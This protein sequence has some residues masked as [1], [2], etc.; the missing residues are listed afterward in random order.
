MFALQWSC[1]EEHQW[2]EWIYRDYVKRLINPRITYKNQDSLITFIWRD[3]N[4]PFL[5]TGSAFTDLTNL[6]LKIF[7]EKIPES[8]KKQNLNLLHAG[9]YLNSIYI[10][11]ITIYI[12]F[13]L[14]LQSIS[15]IISDVEMIWSIWEECT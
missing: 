13:T 15:D 9:N 8:S 11:R 4:Q 6:R 1:H 5:S 12:A 10:V 3:Y 2:V 7:W 14:Y